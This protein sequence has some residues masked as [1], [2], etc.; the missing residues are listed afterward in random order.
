MDTS[1]GLPFEPHSSSELLAATHVFSIEVVD[2]SATPWA[3]DRARLR[4]T[5]SLTCRLLE[6]AKGALSLRPGDTF[7]FTTPRWREVGGESDYQGLWSHAE[8][9]V[10]TRVLLLSRGDTTNPAEL[11]REGPTSELH[12]IDRVADVHAAVRC[13]DHL[14]RSA[15]DPARELAACREVFQFVWS[16]RA[17]VHNLLARYLLARSLPT[18]LEGDVWIR[19]SLAQLLGAQDAAAPFRR[20]LADGLALGALDVRDTPT[21]VGWIVEALLRYAIDPTTAD[22]RGEVLDAWL[23]DIVFKDGCPRAP[24][25]ALL[26]DPA[27]RHGIAQWLP[28]EHPVARWLGAG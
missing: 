19:A 13:E 21:Q 10:G 1:T 9:E 26:Q 15:G 18:A 16:V 28:R 14:R 6:H 5:L 24:A 8:A 17:Q 20:A 11:M 3:H 27:L 12:P 23:P 4:Q 2:L 7:V 25:E 22:N